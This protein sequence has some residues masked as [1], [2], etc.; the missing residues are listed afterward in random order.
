MESKHKKKRDSKAEEKQE[1]KK[2]DL[3]PK[4]FTL[5]TNNLESSKKALE[6]LEQL[7]QEQLSKFEYK[8]FKALSLNKKI[9]E[10]KLQ[11]PVRNSM[12]PTVV[13]QAFKARQMPDFGEVKI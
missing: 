2:A 10:P 5:R 12:P 8:P 1:S 7:K 9:L 11:M 3:K 13:S 6:R 4:E